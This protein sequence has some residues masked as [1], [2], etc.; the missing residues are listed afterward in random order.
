VNELERSSSR[1]ACNPAISVIPGIRGADLSE[2]LMEV[3]PHCDGVI[4]H[5]LRQP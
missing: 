2:I 3:C 1:L 4:K 5:G